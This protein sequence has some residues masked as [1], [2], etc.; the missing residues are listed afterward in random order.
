MYNLWTLSGVI[1]VDFVEGQMELKGV[2]NGHAEGVT[3]ISVSDT[4]QD[5]ILSASDDNT[6]IQWFHLL[7]S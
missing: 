7:F 6:I 2:L 4:K 3:T 5:M 1:E